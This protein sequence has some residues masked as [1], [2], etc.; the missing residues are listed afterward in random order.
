MATNN[1]RQLNQFNPVRNNYGTLG[2]SDFS[3]GYSY[4]NQSYGK[5]I[6][7]SQKIVID[8]ISDISQLDNYTENTIYNLDGEL[9]WQDRNILLGRYEDIVDFINA[10]NG[11]AIELS[12]LSDVPA[13][14]TQG[15]TDSGKFLRVNN[16]RL[17]WHKPI[18]SW[19]ELGLPAYSAASHSGHSLQV[20]DAG[21]LFWGATGSLSDLSEFTTLDGYAELDDYISFSDI[22]DNT[23]KKIS[24]R[25]LMD[26]YHLKLSE[27]SEELPDIVTD[28]DGN[29]VKNPLKEITTKVEFVDLN[30]DGIPETELPVE[31]TPVTAENLDSIISSDSGLEIIE[32]CKDLSGKV[33]DCAIGDAPN[34]QVVYKTKQLS[35]AKTIESKRIFAI[36]S[37]NYNAFQGDGGITSAPELVDFYVNFSPIGGVERNNI[38]LGKVFNNEFASFGTALKFL[39]DAT[40]DGGEAY[41]LV[42]GNV[43]QTGPLGAIVNTETLNI[44]DYNLYMM[45]LEINSSGG[46][47]TDRVWRSDSGYQAGNCVQDTVASNRT[48]PAGDHHYYRCLKNHT[49]GNTRPANDTT[50]WVRLTANRAHMAFSVTSGNE[51]RIVNCNGS[52]ASELVEPFA[53]NSPWNSKTLW[54]STY[55]NNITNYQKFGGIGSNSRAS[56]TCIL[57][58]TDDVAYTATINLWIGNSGITNIV[59]L[60]FYLHA[61]QR[62]TGQ[63]YNHAMLRFD[64]GEFNINNTN[65]SFLPSPRGMSIEPRDTQYHLIDLIGGCYVRS[66]DSTWGATDPNPYGGSLAKHGMAIISD[67]NLFSNVLINIQQ[68]SR[69]QSG[70]EYWN[71]LQKDGTLLHSRV[72]FHGQFNFNIFSRLDGGSQFFG[73]NI[74]HTFSPEATF[75]N[76]MSAGL[77]TNDGNLNNSKLS[78]NKGPTT[79]QDSNWSTNGSQMCSFHASEFSS[80]RLPGDGSASVPGNLGYKLLTNDGFATIFGYDYL[81]QFTS[82][83]S[84]NSS[85]KTNINLS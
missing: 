4:I 10:D 84:L 42:K 39:D 22:S 56:V 63:T 48:D 32:V 47:H 62:T 13:Y 74:G 3:W 85:E 73:G 60:C 38:L 30:G 41:L 76:T 65:F 16:G 27:E 21:N 6:N 52:G 81:N 28:S 46:P 2:T 19:T 37:E 20:N 7:L 58:T 36:V 83:Q 8:S 77:F 33:V 26:S 9:K 54:S 5:S 51:C 69:F 55:K 53:N 17:E 49:S 67:P 50:N 12:S 70:T 11:F 72:H 23:T 78:D 24:I 1:S 34:P 35:I 43:I 64:K 59:G 14:S 79:L 25:H 57:P 80:I 61:G 71:H 31:I 45:V 44:L 15:L 68:G 29:E 18:V 75:T 66:Y 82:A 40:P